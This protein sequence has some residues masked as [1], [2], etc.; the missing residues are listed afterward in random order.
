[1]RAEYSI[2]G[3]SCANCVNTIEKNISK[4]AGVTEV[5]LNP[6]T[7]ILRVEFEEEKV[8]SELLIS[9]VEKLGYGAEEKTERSSFLL[10]ISGMS[11]A[12][13]VNRVEK[14]LSKVSGVSSVSVNLSLEQARIETVTGLKIE[15][16]I[17]AVEDEGYGA[18]QHTEVKAKDES[19]LKMLVI[20]SALLSAPLSLAMFAGMLN[21]PFDF[22]HNPFLQLALAT[23][24]QFVIGYR[25]YKKAFMSLKSLS[26]GMDL[27]VVLGTSAAYFFSIYNIFFRNYP[28]G[29]MPELYFEASA[30]IITL[31]L[32]GKYFEARSKGKTSEALQK[33]VKLK[34]S[35]AHAIMEGEEQDVDVST[36]TSGM[37]LAVRPGEQVPVDGVVIEG[38]SA[39]DESMITGES[40]PVEKRAG[41]KVTGATLNTYG[42]FVFEATRVGNETMLAKIIQYIENA[43]MKKA[44]VQRVADRVSGIFVP[45]IVL[46][47]AVTLALWFFLTGDINTALINAVAVLVIACPCAL[48][49]A[50]PTAIMVGTGKAAEF[51]IL[52]KDGEALENASRIK[53]IVFDK[54]GTITEGKL[55]VQKIVSLSDK[56]E[57][58]IIRLAAVAE[59]RS[60]HPIGR[61]IYEY[62]KTKNRAIDEPDEFSVDPGKGVSIKYQGRK[63]HVGTVDYIKSNNVV[64]DE[65][66]QTHFTIFEEEALTTV[67]L[68]LDGKVEA[69]IGLSDTLRKNAAQAVKRLQKLGVET[70]MITGD[71]EK[72]ANAIAGQVGI[73]KTY[74]R[75]LP[76]Q[77]AEILHSLKQQ[78]ELIA[79]V[80]D[81]INDA[82]ALVSADVGIALGSGT[83]IAID[84]SD[85]TIINNDIQMAAEV[86]SLSKKIM[87]KIYQNLFWAFFYN[88]LG[89]PFAALGF[90]SPIIAGAAMAFSSVSVVTNSLLLK[91][92]KL[93]R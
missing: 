15:A 73:E 37:K 62:G 77:K 59:K 34:P 16:L 82:P 68:A 19:H 74:A 31:V 69:V 22:L 45:V 79:M 54:T 64:F 57:D 30:I 85:I 13:C 28:S 14:S 72:T 36:V 60:E 58:E 6:S 1:M 42:A 27:L 7:D 75:V 50:T 2:S 78:G 38:T 63:V 24:V 47:A 23:P 91:R 51:G 18:K 5:L 65:K 70:V 66:A 53:K 83:D 32:L 9:T 3:I 52:I 56:S 88:T 46:I 86:I 90:L 93:K 21:L 61:T 48:G 20:I 39:I 4:V 25:F 29:M 92:V 41:D 43:Q 35:I 49:L 44:P 87:R 80:G 55:S 76:E 40:V 10:D 12:A 71:S 89:I 8:T 26:P 17:K 84:S 67:L 81:G 33:L 11:C